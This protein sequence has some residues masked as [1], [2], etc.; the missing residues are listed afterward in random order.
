MGYLS[1]SGIAESDLSLEQQLSWHFSANCYPPVPSLMIPVAVEAI[2]A[3]H[4]DGWD[5]ILD[6][7]EGVSFRG[8]TSVSAGDV[9]DGLHLH[10]FIDTDEEY[11]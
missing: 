11:N 2:E 4:E 9:I 1:A 5:T 6:L 7:P 10:A 3:V 8:A